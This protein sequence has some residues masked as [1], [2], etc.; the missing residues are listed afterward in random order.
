MALSS[1]EILSKLVKRMTPGGNEDV[2][3]VNEYLHKCLHHKIHPGKQHCKGAHTKR[4]IHISA[5]PHAD[6][7]T[8]ALAKLVWSQGPKHRNQGEFP[9]WLRRL[10]T[11]VVDQAKKIR[12]GFGAGPESRCWVSD[13]PP[14]QEGCRNA[15]RVEVYFKWPRQ[16]GESEFVF[17]QTTQSPLPWGKNHLLKIYD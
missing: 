8:P 15:N 5:F 14:L 6:T 2:M 11:T 13:F 1:R 10:E 12:L 17:I 7:P 3:R 9:H 16:I 4:N